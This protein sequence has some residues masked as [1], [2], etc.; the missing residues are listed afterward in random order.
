MGVGGRE[1]V[2]PGET[3]SQSG[4]M[5]NSGGGEWGC[6]YSVVNVLTVKALCA[7][8]FMRVMFVIHI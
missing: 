1:P 8:V 5:K 6:P 4:K 7:H 2:F 3:E